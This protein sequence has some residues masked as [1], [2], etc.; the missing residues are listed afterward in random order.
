M[1]C[2]EFQ[3][4]WNTPM[5]SLI[6]D[7]G[8]IPS[9]LSVTMLNRVTDVSMVFCIRLWIFSWYVKYRYIPMHTIDETCNIS[10][11]THD[12][13]VSEYQLLFYIYAKEKSANITRIIINVTNDGYLHIPRV[14]GIHS[15][16]K[17]I[18][19]RLWQT[20]GS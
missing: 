16:I 17:L 14:N 8:T 20:T 11:R 15:A 5:F 1:I 19:L 7:I 10:P 4:I 3:F 2:S 12:Y 6:H 13:H 9:Q 18:W